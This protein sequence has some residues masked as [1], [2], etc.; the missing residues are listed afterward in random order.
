MTLA[1]AAA[2]NWKNLLIVALVVAMVV[3]III[4]R[5]RK[6]EKKVDEGVR[7]TLERENPNADTFRIV[8]DATAIHNA[9]GLDAAWYN[10]AGWTE[11]EDSIIQILKR[12][13]RNTFALLEA[14]YWEKYSRYLEADIRSFFRESQLEQI[15]H[16]L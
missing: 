16:V 14:A 13:N 10:P 1:K 7:R 4:L 12:Y 5:R 8:S 15:N 3:T 11:D 6:D 2:K 9:F